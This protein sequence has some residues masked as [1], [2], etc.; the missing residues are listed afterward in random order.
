MRSLYISQ[1]GCQLTLRQE[2]VLVQLREDVVDRIQLPLLEQILIFGRS[3]VTT[4]VIQSCLQRQIP[5]AYLSHM[6]RCYGRLMPVDQ[7]AYALVELQYVLPEAARLRVAQQLVGA[8]LLNSRVLL[9]RQQRRLPQADL[10]SAIASLDELAERAL[11]AQTIPQVLGFEGAGAAAYFPAL[12]RCLTNSDFTFTE[13]SRRP[14]KDPVNAVLSFGY[15]VLWSHVLFA[16]ENQGLDA[17][18]ACLHQPS[19]RHPALASDLLEQFRAPIVDSLMLYLVNHHILKVEEDFDFQPDACY[20]NH[21]GR[22]RYLQ[23][24]LTRM[25]ETVQT[26]NGEDVRWALLK[27]QIKAFIRCLQRPDDTYAAYRIR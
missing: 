26:E 21:S 11:T 12:G 1:Q 3:Q 23:A 15:Q 2:T 24:F 25:H 16:I 6:G 13:R 5:L 18:R 17:Y 8:K 4:S 19:P 10:A 7:A 22:R 27:Q 20:L 9:Q 14:P